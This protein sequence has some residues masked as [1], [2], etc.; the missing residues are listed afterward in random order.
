MNHS[1]LL[2]NQ[3]NCHLDQQYA[4]QCAPFLIGLKI[5][6]MIC[7]PYSEVSV[8]RDVFAPFGII[9]KVVLRCNQRA[10]LIL[11]REKQLGSYMKNPKVKEYLKLFGYKSE[12]LDYIFQRFTKRYEAYRKQ[13]DTFPHE[14]GFLLGYPVDDVIGYIENNG[15]NCLYTGYWKVYTNLP[16]SLALFERFN[17]A[18]E[19]VM[20]MLADGISI[21]NIVTA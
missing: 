19:I 20:R 1:K 7:V 6:S 11:Y 17:Q 9:C 14:L 16:E 8:I 2:C 10:T 13:K 12:S 18:K 4:V 3:Q 5:S 15:K 21:A